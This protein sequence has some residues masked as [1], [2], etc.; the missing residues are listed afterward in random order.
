M[1]FDKRMT[2]QRPDDVD[3]LIDDYLANGHVPPSEIHLTASEISDW[4]QMIG[5]PDRF[6]A[7]IFDQDWAHPQRYPTEGSMRVLRILRDNLGQI[8][9]IGR[10]NK[11]LY[12]LTRYV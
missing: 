11:Y 3:S 6:N 1:L 10:Q 2:L 12:V 9:L 5:N 8:R 4:T 7:E